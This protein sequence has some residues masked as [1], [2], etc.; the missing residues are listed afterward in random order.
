MWAISN[1]TVLNHCS[2]SSWFLSVQFCY[3]FSS[4]FSCGFQ[5]CFSI[6]LLQTLQLVIL[7]SKKTN[8]ILCYSNKD[9]TVTWWMSLVF[10]PSP[11]KAT[12]TNLFIA[13][14]LKV[15]ENLL[16]ICHP[17]DNVQDFLE[18]IPLLFVHWNCHLNQKVAVWKSFST[19]S[20]L[21]VKK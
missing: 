14:S 12:T 1:N 21:K 18:L 16:Y 8:Q 6:P 13:N 10:M 20:M 3:Q 2:A 9:N 7:W 17:L 19:P 5:M 4:W 11:F 15:V